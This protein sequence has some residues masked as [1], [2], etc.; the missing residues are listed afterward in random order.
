MVFHL[1]LLLLVLLVDFLLLFIFSD[2]NITHLL[3]ESL[4]HSDSI[5]FNLE[6]SFDCTCS[7]AHRSWERSLG[8]AVCKLAAAVSGAWEGR[9]LERGS[10]S[11]LL[12]VAI[13][14]APISELGPTTFKIG[15]T[16]RLT[17]PGCV[18]AMPLQ[19]LPVV[20]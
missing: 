2:L 19:Q 15:S 18:K 9:V 16:L 17:K 10:C 20:G 12:A 5:F 6:L 14:T 7:T 1:L 13:N 8:G 3:S 11:S 4:S